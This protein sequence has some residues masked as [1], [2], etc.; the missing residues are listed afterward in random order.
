MLHIFRH[1]TSCF[2]AEGC[3]DIQTFHLRSLGQISQ[4]ISAWFG[5]ILQVAQFLFIYFLFV[6]W[7]RD[8]S[9]EINLSKQKTAKN[10]SCEIK[11]KLILFNASSLEERRGEESR[12]SP[13]R[14]VLL[15]HYTDVNKI[16]LFC[17]IF[18][19]TSKWA[20]VCSRNTRD[21][22]IKRNQPLLP[23]ISL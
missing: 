21:P 4:Q 1:N 23:T 22:E 17:E 19:G 8:M 9:V 20:R 16:I 2:L 5:I 18:D 6:F 15:A 12:R 14:P 3:E 11:Q 10:T 13:E 7:N